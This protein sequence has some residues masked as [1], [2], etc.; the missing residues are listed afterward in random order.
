MSRGMLWKALFALSLGANVALG[1]F[2]VVH[3]NDA[4]DAA[5]EAGED[6]L[7]RL[8]ATLGLDPAQQA[9]VD[10]IHADFE[11]LHEQQHE[12][13]HAA[14]ARVFEALERLQGD[15]TELDGLVVQLGDAQ[16]AM[17]RGIIE[18]LAG[19]VLE[20]RPEQRT[21]FLAGIR[22]RFLDGGRHGGTH[23]DAA[24]PGPPGSD[25]GKTEGRAP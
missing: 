3:A 15:R 23:G 18:Q 19:I 14:R 12:Q 20:L 2:I 17:R 6:F 5:A 4:D 25:G 1:A 7:P 22:T 16:L 10:R 9:A 11:T 24:E 21:R 8:L 13:L